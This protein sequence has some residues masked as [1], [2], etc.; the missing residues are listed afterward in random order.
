MVSS[1]ISL[2]DHVFVVPVLEVYA[3]GGTMHQTHD[4]SVRSFDLHIGPFFTYQRRYITL[5]SRA[6]ERVNRTIESRDKPIREFTAGRDLNG[7]QHYR[8]QSNQ[9]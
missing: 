7:D 4:D 3:L 5:Q 2:E 8:I 1:L 9:L 6:I